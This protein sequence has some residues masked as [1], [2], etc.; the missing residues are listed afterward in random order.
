MLFAIGLEFS[1]KKLR[2][3]AGTVGITALTELISM[4]IIGFLLGKVMGW[5][6]MDSIFLGAMLSMSSTTIIAKAFDDLKMKGER[7]TGSVIG[8]LVV[9]DL[10]AILMMVVLSTMAVSATLDGKEL[11]M[12]VVRLV[13]FLLVWYVGGVFLIPTILKWARKFMSEETLTV[14]AVGLCF[15]MVW[16][17]NKAG[18]S[19]ALG[20]FIMG[21]I[22][23]ETLEAEMIH[24]LTTPIKNLFGAVFFVSV[25]MMVNPAILVQYWWQILVITI[26]VVVLKSL[27]SSLGM[28]FSGDNLHNAVRAGMCFGQIGEFSFIIATVGMSFGVIDDFLYPI[29]VSVSIITT[30]LTPY[31]IKGGEPLFHW[32]EKKVPDSWKNGFGSKEKA[33]KS[34]NGEE[35][36]MKAYLLSQLKNLVLYASIIIALMLICFSL[37]RFIE[38]Y[39]PQP[40]S[41]LVSLAVTLVVMSPFLWAVAFKHGM[42]KTTRKLMAKS[43]FN[44]KSVRLIFIIRILLVWGVA[45]NIHN[46]YLGTGFWNSLGLQN[47]PNHLIALGLS[48]IYVI[49]LRVIT[50]VMHWYETIERRF[51]ENMNKRETLKS[52]VLPEVL[53]ENFTMEKMALSPKSQYVGKRIRETDFRPTYGASVVCVDR[54][55]EIIDLP[56]RDFI[57]YPADEVTF[58]GTE[59]QLAKLRPFV[60]VEDDVLIKER[61][62]SDVDIHNSVVGPNSRYAGVSL[63]DS[64]LLNRFNVMVIAIQRDDEFF[65]N[66]QASFV[67]QHGDIV[68]FVSTETNA[69]ALMQYAY[70][71]EQLSTEQLKTDN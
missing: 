24:K 3:Q 57:L 42:L 70:G 6:Q 65:L 37:C 12:S 13:F 15:F 32:I 30:F 41:G 2:K 55:D 28:L 59:E 4:C 18:F 51:L 43:Q 34:T 39:V 31:M 66:P 25:G 71:T 11:M 22:L 49:V 10:A 50:P 61:P 7:F 40:I 52:F 68:W 33:V 8:V 26:V 19:S 14:F 16:L 27:S 36:T 9:E 63:H 64:D 1:F 17:A 48:V 29:I 20:A 62:D 60:E 54:A 5:S 21:S 53:Q 35:M 58:I 56:R 23:A 69:K 38:E 67:F 45:V 44:K 47:A 46:H